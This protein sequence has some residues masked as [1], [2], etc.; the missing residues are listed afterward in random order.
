MDFL[1]YVKEHEKEIIQAVKELCKIESVLTEFDPSKEAPFGEN[2]NKALHHMIN[3]GKK[4]GFVV[5]NIDNYAAHIEMGEGDD[6]LGVLTHLD[7]VPAKNEGWKF[8]PFEPTVHDGKIY[9]RGTSDDK[10][11]T[12]AAYFAMKFL[13]ALDV[14]FH[15]RVRLIMGTDEE[16]KWRGIAKYL[17]TEEMPTFGFSPDA[18]FPLIHGEK[19]IYV[20]DTTGAFEAD[21]L[22]TFYAGERYNVV[23]EK[24]EATLSIDLKDQFKKF[25]K[26]NDYKGDYKDGRYIVYGKNAHGMTPNLGVNAAFILAKFLS[27]HLDNKFIHYIN[28][29]LSFDPYGEKMELD[30]KHEVMGVLTLNP[31]IF[32]YDESGSMVGQNIRYPKGFNLKSAAL[33]ISN[34]AKKYGLTYAFGQNMP[35]H[36]VEKDDSLVEKLMESYQKVTYDNENKPYTIGGGTYARAL[37]KGV[38]FG[39]VMPGRKDVAHQV[40]EHIFIDDLIE[41][42]AI[43]MEAIYALTRKDVKI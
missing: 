24:A 20:Y 30:I 25:L 39:M 31:G 2:I 41:G 40:D 33:K 27:E 7:V 23:P 17:Q 9:G 16:T 10:G 8:P 19:G 12:I 3:N 1:N 34:A 42:T 5:K 11:P 38:A 26:Y 21:A 43:Y 4:D 18:T 22:K 15:K 28:D 13:K 37:D 14:S 6:V 35:L 36:Y 29:C 32:K